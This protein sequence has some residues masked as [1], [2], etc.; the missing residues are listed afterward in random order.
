M[1]KRDAENSA[2][3]FCHF[4]GKRESLTAS[5]QKFDAPARN[6]QKNSGKAR[7]FSDYFV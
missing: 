7:R 3:L 5:F 1:V 4:D 6:A 2:S